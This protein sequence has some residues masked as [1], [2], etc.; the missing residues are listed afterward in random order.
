MKIPAWIAAAG[1]IGTWLIFVAAIWG[2]RIRSWLFKPRLR[3]DLVDSRGEIITEIILGLD[4]DFQQQPCERQ[5][6][7]Y[8]VSAV[9]TPRWPV[10]HNVQIVITQLETVDPDS[11]A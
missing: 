10:A 4:P 1:V 11:D 8:L 6:R 7:R 2:E 5:A 9:N 3:V